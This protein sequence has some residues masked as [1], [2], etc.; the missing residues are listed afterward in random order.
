MCLAAELLCTTTE[1]KRDQMQAT[2]CTDDE[3]DEFMSSVNEPVMK[4]EEK[5][6]LFTAVLP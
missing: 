6:F 2:N 5:F 3:I 4:F 1:T